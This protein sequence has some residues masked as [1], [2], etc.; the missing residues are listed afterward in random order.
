MIVLV[1]QLPYTQAM[2][3]IRSAIIA[4]EATTKFARRVSAV[5]D[6][7]TSVLDMGAHLAIYRRALLGK[8]VAM[9]TK[10]TVRVAKITRPTKVGATEDR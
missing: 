7:M 9:P 1:H 3:T 6:G 2:A 8:L 4:A 5:A 10:S